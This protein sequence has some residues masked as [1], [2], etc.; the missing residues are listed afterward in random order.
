[1][2][3]GRLATQLK[4]TYDEAKELLNKFWGSFPMIADTLR[5]LANNAVDRR[6][7]SCPLDGRRRYLWNFDFDVKKEKAHA[8]NIAKN[9]PFQGGNAS[10]VKRA[11]VNIREG[12]L[13][14]AWT[15]ADFRLLITVHD[16]IICECRE[17]LIDEATKLVSDSMIQAAEF[18][19]KSVPMTIDLKVGD[20]WLH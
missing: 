9:M 16:E 1:M 20:C 11:L 17:E 19:V 5:K 10:I 15:Y 8:E 13:A 4:I 2:K 7:A 3:A 18:Y 12:A 14:K 6:Y